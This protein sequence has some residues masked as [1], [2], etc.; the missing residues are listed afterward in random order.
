MNVSNSHIDVILV[1][2]VAMLVCVSCLV[3]PHAFPK[4]NVLSFFLPDSP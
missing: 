4:K 3:V 1:N 2:A